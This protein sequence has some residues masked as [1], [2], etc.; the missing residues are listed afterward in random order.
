MLGKNWRRRVAALVVGSVA[1]VP[2]ASSP[3]VAEEEDGVR[4]QIIAGRDAAFGEFPSQVALL[5]GDVADPFQA[6]FCGGAVIAPDWVLTAAHCIGDPSVPNMDVYAGDPDL[7]GTG[8]RI[9]VS[10]IVMHPDWNPGNLSGDLALLR[11]SSPT[12]APPI[13]LADG[14][15]YG[16]GSI[17]TLAGWG[18]LVAYDAG[19]EVSQEYA[20]YLQAVD[21]TVWSDVDCEQFPNIGPVDDATQVCAGDPGSFGI[22]GPD[23]CQGDSGGPLAVFDPNQGWVQIGI[24]SYGPTCGF[25]PTVYTE[26]AAFRGFI[27]SVVLSLPFNDIGGSVHQDN[28]VLVYD[29]GIAAGYPDGTYRPDNPVT[30]G[31]M[32]TFLVRA[33]GLSPIGGPSPFTDV[34][35]TTHAESINAL[36]D[37][38]I[39]GGFPDGSYRPDDTVSRAQMATFLTRALGL[40]AVGGGYFTDTSD[41]P[42]AGSI[43]AVYEAGITAGYPDGT[44]RPS[45]AV[46][47]GQMATFLTRSL[48]SEG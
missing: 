4:A 26:V 32:A 37:A 14:S 8:E 31:Q 6:Q 23:A 11:L 44:Y 39:A 29:A 41:S 12:S 15:E 9:P 40:A 30:R 48:L 25:A 20:T 34:D 16:P 7:Y 19:E 18:G 21:M 47:R 3:A 2:F 38:G 45:N 43:D 28:I 1:M 33:L 17:A 46:T 27:D 36:A 13:V 42:H 5:F 10:E 24:V 35:G 22:G